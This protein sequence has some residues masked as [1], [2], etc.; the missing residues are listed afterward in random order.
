MKGFQEQV[1]A[2][3][4]LGKG[5]SFYEGRHTSAKETSSKVCF[6]DAGTPHRCIR[7]DEQVCL[8]PFFALIEASRLT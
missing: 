3:L 6:L 5:W 7:S 2:H 1:Q 8:H 4:H